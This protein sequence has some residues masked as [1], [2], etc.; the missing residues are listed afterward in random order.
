M[1]PIRGFISSLLFRALIRGSVPSG[2]LR[3]RRIRRR[4]ERIVPDRLS[5]EGFQ[6]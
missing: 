3:N 5:R 4:S 1:T 6:G 2:A